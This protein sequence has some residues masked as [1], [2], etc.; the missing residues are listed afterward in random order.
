MYTEDETMPARPEVFRETSLQLGS[1]LAGRYRL[2]GTLGEG[3]MGVVFR[4]LDERVGTLVAVKVFHRGGARSERELLLA[5]KV[6]HPRVVRI[7]DIGDEGSLSFITMDMVDG[8]TLADVLD[9]GPLSVERALDLGTEIA[10]GVA[11]IHA[12]GIV[13]R[14]LKPAN[15]LLD[16]LGHAQ[17]SDFGIAKLLSDGAQS[18]SGLVGTLDYLAPEQVR[19]GRVDR[20]ADVYA[21]G[22]VLYEMLAGEFPHRGSCAQQ[23]LA[24]RVSGGMVPLRRAVPEVPAWLSGLVDHCLALEPDDRP[25]SMAEVLEVLRA[26]GRAPESRA[27]RWSLP[28][29][30][31]LVLAGM[32][33]AP[34]RSVV[35]SLVEPPS[36]RKL[37]FVIEAEPPHRDLARGLEFLASERAG[38]A[39]GAFGLAPV[40]VRAV[41]ERHQLADRLDASGRQ[42]LAELLEAELAVGRVREA[43]NGWIFEGAHRGTGEAPLRLESSS[44][45]GLLAGLFEALELQVRARP[46]VSSTQ[47]ALLGEALELTSGPQA[48]SALATLAGPG[49]FEASLQQAERVLERDEDEASAILRRLLRRGGLS[50]RNRHRARWLLS[51]AQ[52]EPS[53]ELE[54]LRAWWAEAPWDLAAM[55]ALSEALL[56]S[57]QLAE[58]SALAERLAELDPASPQAWFFR[59]KLAIMAGDSRSAADDYLVRGLLAANRQRDE[60]MRGEILNALGVAYQDLGQ[61]QRAKESF[62]DALEARSH[63]GDARGVV[64]SRLNL[65]QVAMVRGLHDEA[66]SELSRALAGARELENPALE[67]AVH[68]DLGF[69]A[70]ERGHFEAALQAYARALEVFELAED[71]YALAEASGNVAFASLVLGKLEAAEA[72]YARAAKLHEAMGNEE[73]L[74]LVEQGRAELARIEGRLEEAE[75][76]LEDSLRVARRLERRDAEIA[77]LG[78]LGRLARLQSRHDEAQTRLS[79]ALGL[80][81]S[82][83]DARAELEFGL[84]RVQLALD[85]DRG[86]AARVALE[87]TLERLGEVRVSDEQQALL[88]RLQ[89]EVRARL[90]EGGLES[91]AS[92]A[93]ALAEASGSAEVRRLVDETRRR[94]LG[95]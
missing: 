46:E 94:H 8:G 76:R 78:G 30:G 47:V 48:S 70:E 62:Q 49:L 11:A 63:F 18:G 59:G 3:G 12:N 53:G 27:F 26:Q 19:G 2:D 44:A 45:S 52:G 24:Q 87:Q 15:I 85:Q 37:A 75:Q 51:R 23:R 89:I 61:L 28:A 66:E 90:G 95:R 80:A 39:A 91:M 29:V 88:L 82:M 36:L 71:S 50:D 57:G 83:G 22:L 25:P 74:L 35:P 72:A 16:R 5:R 64:V 38:E 7:H 54:V 58:A 92:Q 93:W 20:R 9:G 14:D 69:L 67:G 32:M 17:I 60:V 33:L 86:E 13:H 68:S 73:G 65:A 31:L 1:L 84:E 77:A 34:R 56:A 43:A 21:F 6:S 81:R 10:E 79:Q 40:R 42:V 4:A 41:L 55:R